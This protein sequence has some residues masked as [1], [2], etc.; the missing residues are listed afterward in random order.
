MPLRIVLELTDKDLR[1]LRKEMKRAQA[2]SREKSE[3][4]V[5]QAA[6]EVLESAK[7]REVPEF[8]AKH[9][10]TL[11]HLIGML[12]D[13]Q[14]LLP[15]KERNRV[16][17]ALLYFANPEDI[18]QDDVPVI[19]FLD[20]A[21]MIELIERELRHEID[22][23]RDFCEFRAKGGKAKKPDDGVL[24]KRRTQLHERMRRRRRTG[25]SKGG[26]SPVGFF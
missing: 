26:G 20:D 1:L 6:D 16:R 2:I 22:A 3:L 15:D 21:I 10:E 17:T 23:Y 5:I 7:K 9:L 18:I 8:I 4:E 25:R 11:Q 12:T 14:W 19:G 24:A 13:R